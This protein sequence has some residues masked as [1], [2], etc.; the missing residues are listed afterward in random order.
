MIE[1][2]SIREWL[3]AFDSEAF[4][5]KDFKIQ[6]KAGWFDWFCRDTSLRGKT[7]ALAPKVKQIA[8]ST[9]VNIDT[10]YVFFKNNC[11]VNGS[12]YDDFRICDAKTGDVIFTIVPKSGHKVKL[13]QTEVWGREND[14]KEPLYKGDWKGALKWFGV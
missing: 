6:I 14:F 11:P 5:S 7:Y 2:L 12:L 3:K 13:G 9:K 10:M 4:S 1:K 8:K